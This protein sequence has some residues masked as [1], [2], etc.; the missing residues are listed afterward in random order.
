M[1][2]ELKVQSL[3]YAYI[4]EQILINEKVLGKG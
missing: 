4:P 1:C 3:S 2:M